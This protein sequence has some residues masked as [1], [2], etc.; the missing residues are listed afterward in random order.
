MEIGDAFVA[1]HHGKGGAVFIGGFDV[2]LDL[3]LLVGREFFHFGNEVAETV[4][5][6]H[7]ELLEGGGVLGDEVLE[8]DLH[9]TAKDDG[10]ADLHHSS[11]HVQGEKDAVFLGLGDLLGKEADERGLAHEGAVDDFAGLQRGAFL[12]HLGAA[13]CA[14]EF[15]LHVRGFIHADGFFIGEEVALAAHG[16]HAGL[17]IGAPLAHGMRVGLGVVLHGLRRAAVA[18]AL[19]QHG[20]HGAAHDLGVAGLD[21]LL[22]IGL[23]IL[24]EIGHGVAFALKLGNGGLQL[25]YGGG[26]VRQLDDVR[27]RLQAELAEVG[28]V[29][30]LLL[31]VGEEIGEIRQ[32]AAC[33]GDVARLDRDARGFGEGL[34]DGQEGESGQQG[35]FVG[36]GVDDLRGHD[37]RGNLESRRAKR[38]PAPAQRQGAQVLK[39]TPGRRKNRSPSAPQWAEAGIGR[40]PSKASIFSRQVFQP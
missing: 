3:R 6:V 13:V 9:G 4:A 25:R 21:V 30:G 15:D 17:G 2:C 29:I 38:A 23:R 1:V 35:S 12:E 20:V 28:E 5:E 32:D 18:V 8:E 14:D 33:Q 39:L 36:Q 24:G 34:N 40:P 27:G 10:V 16:A 7:A 19:A 31:R 26:D 11:L 37:L 22:G